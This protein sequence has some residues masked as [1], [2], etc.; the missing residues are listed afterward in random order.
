MISD[1]YVDA[2]I[3]V[4]ARDESVAAVLREICRLETA[5]RQGALDVVG[6]HL[7]A[8]DAQHDVLE[9]LD[10][11]RRDDVAHRIAERLPRGV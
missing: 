8:R 5:V 10:A 6:A 3:Q 2:I 7:R 11:L 1:E 4:A 9:C